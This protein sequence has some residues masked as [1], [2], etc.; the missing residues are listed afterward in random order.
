[1][2][3]GLAL[4]LGLFLSS[5]TSFSMVGHAETSDLAVI[6]NQNNFESLSLKDVRNIFTG[7]LTQYPNYETPISVVIL[8]DEKYRTVFNEYVLEATNQ[9][10]KKSWSRMIFTGKIDPPH[11]ASTTREVIDYVA[12]NDNAIAFVPLEEVTNNVR[13]AYIYQKE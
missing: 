1:M 3:K 11:V 12:K 7:K 9:E 5:S 13:I 2:N 10:L 8:D 6:V 4:F